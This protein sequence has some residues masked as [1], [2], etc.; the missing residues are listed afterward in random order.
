[1]RSVDPLLLVLVGGIV[2]F[3]LWTC[4]AHRSGRPQR[5]RVAEPLG[6]RSPRAILEERAALEAEDLDQMLA[7]HNARRRRRG[8]PAQSVEEIERLA[9]SGARA[10]RRSLDGIDR[11]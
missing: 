5:R 6:L 4:L 3:G 7:A 9:A 1:M 2:A 11:V 8:E 10:G